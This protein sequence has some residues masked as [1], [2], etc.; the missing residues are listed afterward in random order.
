MEYFF[1]LFFLIIHNSLSLHV[2]PMPEVNFFLGKIL[3][4]YHR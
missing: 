1:F 2:S 4:S 3:K